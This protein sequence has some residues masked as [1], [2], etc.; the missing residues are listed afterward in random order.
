MIV[1]CWSSNHQPLIFRCCFFKP[2][3]E[4]FGVVDNCFTNT[5]TTIDIRQTSLI[6]NCQ[7]VIFQLASLPASNSAPDQPAICSHLFGE[8]ASPQS[9]LELVPQ[10]EGRRKSTRQQKAMHKKTHT[11][12]QISC[13][14]ISK[15]WNTLSS[16]YTY[17]YFAVI[18]NYH[19]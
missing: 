6:F 18:D 19:L 8:L 11:E 2:F 15:I 7:W 5:I 9:S 16:I 17:L 14:N 10:A 1:E 3:T 13:Q 12:P 4:D